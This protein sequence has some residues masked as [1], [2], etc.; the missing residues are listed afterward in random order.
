MFF[1]FQILQ[2]NY[3]FLGSREWIGILI[4]ITFLY[5]LQAQKTF[6]CMGKSVNVRS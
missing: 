3:Q 4:A 5:V 1:I 6:V 2:T